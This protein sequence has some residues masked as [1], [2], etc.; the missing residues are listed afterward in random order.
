MALFKAGNIV[1]GLAVGVGAAVV[2]PAVVPVLRPRAKAVIKAGLMA[3]D[4]GRL[5]LTDLNER[6]GDIVAEARAE[7]AEAAQEG[8][9]EPAPER[10]TPTPPAA[11]TGAR[12]PA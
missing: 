11:E 4:R 8:K 2:A 6:T 12:T 7:L 10:R 3:Y 9:T 1:T 5:T